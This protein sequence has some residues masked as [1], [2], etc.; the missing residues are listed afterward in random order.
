MTDQHGEEQSLDLGVGEDLLVQQHVG[1]GHGHLPEL[2]VLGHPLGLCGAQQ[3][4][5]LTQL[6]K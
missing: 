4:P 5:E 1:L 6:T 3:R 2:V